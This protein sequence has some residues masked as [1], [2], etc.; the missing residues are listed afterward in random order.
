LLEP[1]TNLQGP[2][3]GVRGVLEMVWFTSTAHYLLA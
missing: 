2:D 1:F 3:A